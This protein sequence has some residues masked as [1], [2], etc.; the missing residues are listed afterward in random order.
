MIRT[1]ERPPVYVYEDEGKNSVI[2]SALDLQNLIGLGEFSGRKSY[3]PELQKKIHQLEK[4]E[5]NFRLLFENNEFSIHNE[6]FTAVFGALGEL[7]NRG[8]VDLKDYFRNYPEE[9]TRIADLVKI[10]HVNKF[11]LSLFEASNEREY[12]DRFGETRSLKS[13]QVFRAILYAIWSGASNYR[14]EVFFKSLRGRVFPAIISLPI[15]KNEK[16]FSCIPVSIVD[17]SEQKETENALIESENNYRQIFNATSDAIFIHDAETGTILDVN[18]Q[19]LQMYGYT[20]NEAL[21]LTVGDI[22]SQENCFTQEDALLYIKRAMCEGPQLFE[23]HCKKKNGTLFWTEVNLKF[24]NINNNKRVLAVV[25]DISERKRVQEMHFQNEKML[26]IGALAAGIAH[27]FNNQLTG[28]M[29]FADLMREEA[30]NQSNLREYAHNIIKASRHAAALTAQLL[31]FSRKGKYLNVVV[32]IHPI[33]DEVINLLRHSVNKKIRISESFTREKILVRGDPSQL[34][35]AILNLG[36]NACDA[37]PD[38]GSLEFKTFTKTVTEKTTFVHAFTI[39]AGD[40][41]CISI[42]DSGTGI[43]GTVINHIFEPFFTT[44]AFGEGTGMGL[45]AAFGTLTNHHGAIDVKSTLGHGSEFCLYLPLVQN[46][47]EKYATLPSKLHVKG[48]GHILLVD[49]EVTVCAV[50]RKMMEKMGY[51]VTACLNGKDA[52]L[53]YQRNWHSIDLVILDLSMPELSGTEVFSILKNFNPR[54]VVLLSSGYSIDMEAQELLDKGAAGF[55]QKPFTMDALS[56][57]LA[58]LLN[59]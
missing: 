15:P 38:G 28:I 44:K 37:M 24:T 1:C 59:H 3:Y 9:V 55:I 12:L 5:S 17:I 25:R 50:T 7:R 53:R 54:I 4:S 6:D 34:Q 29:G 14:S 33:I 26:S 13:M 30:K 21:Q 39:D 36:I 57:K 41:V 27:D 47:G 23:W 46:N 52:V 16:E 11:T 42:T 31:A 22:S 20:K 40:Y 10:V 45:A 48:R 32:E 49:D 56:K 18:E 2:D 58:D 51:T 43:A 8:I 19:M 35:N